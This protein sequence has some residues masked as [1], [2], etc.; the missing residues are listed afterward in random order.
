M[1]L[2]HVKATETVFLAD[3]KHSNG[4]FDGMRNVAGCMYM[5]YSRKRVSDYFILFFFFFFMARADTIK[6]PIRHKR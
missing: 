6:A 5:Y 2:F 3:R 1:G 4:V